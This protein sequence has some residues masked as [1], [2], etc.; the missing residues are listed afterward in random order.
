MRAIRAAS[1]AL[2]GA[3]ALG[4]AAAPLA[5]AADTQASIY[6]TVSPSTV[7]PGGRVALSAS[8]CNTTATA[9]SG[10]FD[11]VTI[12]PGTSAVATVDPAARPG[13]QYSVQ[14]TC[15]S[16]RGSFNLTIAGGR[17]TPT[18]SSTATTSSAP[19]TTPS[20]VLGGLGGSV[21]EMDTGT[22]ALGASL[23]LAAAGTTVFVVRR[24]VYGHRH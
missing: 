4:W 10:I 23:V 1:A 13:A 7:A 15:G 3:T 9:S 8:G 14:F 5:A 16:Q 24:R 17:S 18:T 22:I 21:E 11:A 6:F 19:T 2:L 12:R 20:G